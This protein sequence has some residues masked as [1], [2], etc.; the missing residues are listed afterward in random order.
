[1]RYRRLPLYGLCI[2]VLAIGF[3]PSSNTMRFHRAVGELNSYIRTNYK[4]NRQI[5]CEAKGSIALL[6]H[7][8]DVMRLV[9]SQPNTSGASVSLSLRTDTTSV[10]MKEF[11]DT[12]SDENQAVLTKT[13]ENVLAM[14]RANN[15]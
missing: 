7:Q 1:M 12:L 10:E 9:Y 11:V 14:C 15:T 4:E 13:L 8:Q 5:I 2:A 6:E 3:W